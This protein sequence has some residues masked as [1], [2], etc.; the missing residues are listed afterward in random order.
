M[1]SIALQFKTQILLNICKVAAFSNK[2]HL[3]IYKL[4]TQPYTPRLKEILST[5]GNTGRGGKK[6]YVL[7]IF[8]NELFKIWKQL[9]RIMPMNNNCDNAERDWRK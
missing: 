4:W 2:I 6:S 3:D 1:R 7:R 8:Q 9:N 5:E